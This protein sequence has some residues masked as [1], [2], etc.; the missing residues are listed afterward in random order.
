MKTND[1][2]EEYY[3]FDY[4]LGTEHHFEKKS[5]DNIWY[6]KICK[7]LTSEEKDIL[8]Y[9]MMGLTLEKCSDKTGLS[10]K[11]VRNRLDKCKKKISPFIKEISEQFVKNM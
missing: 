9:R 3:S 1:N 10:I 7:S 2:G 6:D 11:Q 8:D 4:I 5:D